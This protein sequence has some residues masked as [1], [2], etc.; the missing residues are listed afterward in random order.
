MVA[1]IESMIWDRAIDPDWAELSPDVAR[2]I[3]QISFKKADVDRMNELAAM[4]REDRLSDEDREELESYNRIGHLL[5]M[6]H[7]RARRAM[8]NR[9]GR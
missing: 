6:L 9:Q 8:D 5:A 1:N 2:A 3:L 7:S 4:A